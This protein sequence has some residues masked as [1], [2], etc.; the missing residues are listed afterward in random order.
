MSELRGL[1]RQGAWVPLDGRVAQGTGPSSGLS[2]SEWQLPPPPR[3]PGGTG[4]WKKGSTVLLF[5][6]DI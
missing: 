5:L 6:N 4:V 3:L 1:E 2:R